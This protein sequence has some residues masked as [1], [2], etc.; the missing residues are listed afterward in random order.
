MKKKST[1]LNCQIEFV[2]YESCSIGKYCC[3]QCQQDYQKKVII[4]DW[5]I[6]KYDGVTCKN[7]CARIANSIRTYLIN[8]SNRCCSKCFINLD[9]PSTRESGLQIHHKDGDALNNNKNNLEVLCPN[10]HWMTPNMGSKNKNATRKKKKIIY[11]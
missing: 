6:G 10:C 5:L 9:N 7:T 1:C 8:E 2:Y 3:N 11:M 4:K